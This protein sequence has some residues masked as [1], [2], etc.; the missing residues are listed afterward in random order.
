MSNVLLRNRGIS[1]M[2]FYRVAGD[3]SAE[4][5]HFLM[6]DKNVPK[7]WRSVV[8]YPMLNLVNDLFCYITEANSKYPTIRMSEAERNAIIDERIR[9]Q[10]ECVVCVNKIYSRM[11]YAMRNVWW[12]KLHRP[13]DN[14][15][16]MRIEYHI[17]TIGTLLDR[18]ETLLK[19][20][21]RSSH[22]MKQL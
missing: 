13:E 14:A 4:I 17:A 8:T 6:S 22:R 21:I 15:E 10:K 18:E 3:L 9:L 12:E 5:S 19:G 16:R 2:E 7:K 11:E 1:E 20:W